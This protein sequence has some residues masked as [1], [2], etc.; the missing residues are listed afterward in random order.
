MK[1]R[2]VAGIYAV[3]LL[4]AAPGC[5]TMLNLDITPCGHNKNAYRPYGGVIQYVEG[6]WEAATGE[7]SGRHFQPRVLALVA[8]DFP[9]CVV[10]D[11]LTLPLVLAHWL[12]VGRD[13]DKT[14]ENTPSR[15]PESSSE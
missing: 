9:L 15:L 11:T 12:L 2:S 6:F 5:G 13:S 14:P 8:L 7:D 10:G 3:A 1:R 4:V